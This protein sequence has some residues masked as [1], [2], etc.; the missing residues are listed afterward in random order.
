METQ[1]SSLLVLVKNVISKV[2][3]AACPAESAGRA[4]KGHKYFVRF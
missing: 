1:L 2:I 4:G 3:G